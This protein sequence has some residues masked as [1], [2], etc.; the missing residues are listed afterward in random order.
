MRLLNWWSTL[1]DDICSFSA[2]SGKPLLAG[3]IG[4][5][6]LADIND[7]STICKRGP[8][9]CPAAIEFVYVGGR[10]DA[11]QV[12]LTSVGPVVDVIPQ[13]RGPHGTFDT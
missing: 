3:I 8:E 6:D 7:Q 13:L 2:H 4:A 11:I 12:Q 5:F 10:K 9:C 1:L